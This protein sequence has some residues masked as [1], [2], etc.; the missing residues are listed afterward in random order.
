MAPPGRGPDGLDHRSPGPPGPVLPR[1]ADLLAATAARAEVGRD[2]LSRGDAT[3]VKVTHGVIRGIRG[4]RDL[5]ALEVARLR[6]TW[7]RDVLV[8]SG[9]PAVM[10]AAGTKFRPAPRDPPPPAGSLPQ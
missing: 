4:G 5:P 7:W 2:L 6:A 9:Y 1:Y 3:R 10:A 8:A